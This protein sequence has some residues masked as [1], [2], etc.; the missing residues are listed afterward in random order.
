MFVSNV[1]GNS[2]S[3]FNINNGPPPASPTVATG[4]HPFGMALD[5]MG[6][7]LFVANKVDNNVSAFAVNSTS[8][9]LMSVN[10]SP[11]AAGGS[12]P[13]GIVVVAKQ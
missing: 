9:G 7:F 13:A 4:Q 11:F 1:G 5:G 12:G 2:V 8:G 6:N 10:G 3:V